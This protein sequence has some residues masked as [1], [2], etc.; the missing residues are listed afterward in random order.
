MG[1]VIVN[2]YAGDNWDRDL[3]F[4]SQEAGQTDGVHQVA[5]WRQGPPLAHDCS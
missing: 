2:E 4:L 3:E 5:Q 1:R